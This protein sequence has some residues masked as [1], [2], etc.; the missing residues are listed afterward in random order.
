MIDARARSPLAHRAPLAGDD[1]R[2]AE[3]P[4]EGLLALRGEA[5]ELD[6]AFGAATG[7]ALPRACRGTSRGP[8]SSALWLAPDEWLVVTPAVEDAARLA[9]ELALALAGL[10]H[11]VVDVSD[12]YTVVQVSGRATRAALAKLVALDLHPRA[13]RRDEVLGTHLAKAIVQIWLVAG[14]TDAGGAEAR[15]VVRRS[16]ADYVWCLLAEAGREWGL[17]PQRPIGRVRLEAV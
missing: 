8:G 15:V 4:F 14:E 17:D 5:D 2:L 7:L 1:L 6:P 12:Y 9:T 10:R 16:L 11:Q 13:W 3:R